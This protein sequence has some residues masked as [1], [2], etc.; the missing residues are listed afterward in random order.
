MKK[1]KDVR[2]GREGPLALC[3]RGR[4]VGNLNVYQQLLDLL[5][6]TKQEVRESV[7]SGVRPLNYSSE[8]QLQMEVMMKSSDTQEQC[9]TELLNYN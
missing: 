6:G 9:D 5:Y 2:R 1:K 8:T 4:R 7:S 3:C